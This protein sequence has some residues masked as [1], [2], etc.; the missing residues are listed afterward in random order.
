MRNFSGRNQ[1]R[2][3]AGNAPASLSAMEDFLFI[4]VISLAVSIS[5][6]SKK[7]LADRFALAERRQTGET[8]SHQE[9]ESMRVLE[10]PI[11]EALRLDATEYNDR[12]QLLAQLN[13]PTDTSEAILLRIDYSRPSGEVEE[14][15]D[16]LLEIGWQVYTEWETRK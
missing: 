1:S 2:T 3:A 9:Y 10:M 4:L 11:G 16:R 14:L 13:A 15:K 8:V 6:F 5:F 12:N 7:Q